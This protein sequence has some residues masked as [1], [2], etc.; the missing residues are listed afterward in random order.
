M[1][2]IQKRIMRRIM[3]YKQWNIVVV[4]FP[5]VDVAKSKPRPA[6]I[7]SKA[8]F[9]KDTGYH[10]ASMITSAKHPAQNGDTLIT[11]RELSGLTQPSL[12]RLKLFSLDERLIS[13][14]IGHLSDKDSA[15]FQRNFSKN[16]F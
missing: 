11:D 13:S 4:P 2:G 1:N 15:D 12:I 3:T 14:V 5:F 8:E 10:I 6:L 9:G 7:I 16:V